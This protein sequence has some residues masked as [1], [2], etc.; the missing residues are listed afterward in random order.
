MLLGAS[1][2]AT[3]KEGLQQLSKARERAQILA[4]LPSAVLSAA[5]TAAV[6]VLEE[7]GRVGNVAVTNGQKPGCADKDELEPASAVAEEIEW[8]FE[9]VDGVGAYEDADE[10]QP[11]KKTKEMQSM[12]QE[13]PQVME[14]EPHVMESEKA[15]KGVE[16]AGPG[17]ETN[18]VEGTQLEKEAGE[19][20][21]VKKFD[22][23]I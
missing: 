15:S 7:A 20:A 21:H 13:E 9:E 23:N 19:E 14:A 10:Q 16:R 11:A 3:L 12:E 4:A 5:T 17:V 22:E 2:P 18:A 1:G 8:V 6:Q